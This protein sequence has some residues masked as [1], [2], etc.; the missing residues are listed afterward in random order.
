[1]FTESFPTHKILHQYS[2]AHYLIIV[3]VKEL[4]D[5]PKICNWEYNRP[6]D[7]N[8]CEEIAK[9]Y[10]DSKC[11]LDTMFYMAYSTINNFYKIIDGI[12]RYTALK[13]L[14]KENS[15]ELDLITYGDFGSNNDANFI[16]NQY[17]LCNIRINPSEYILKELFQNLN[18]SKP[19]PELYTEEN[20]QA[21]KI[22]IVNQIVS[23]W[24]QK[25]K[26]HFSNST[27]PNLPNTNM[28]NF[29]ELVSY[30]YD[31]YN[32]S[33]TNKELLQQILNNENE[34]VKSNPPKK[35]SI[36][37]LSKCIK[38]GC[39]LFLNKHE[40]LMRNIH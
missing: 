12:H 20:R 39:Y 5:N 3:Q 24:Y 15:K 1:M 11:M 26:Q 14:K 10:Y 33:K 31:K 25:Y 21:E 8:R 16:Y 35:C 18:K 40:I 9:Y 17:I 34:F 13:H 7:L 29:T 4:L 36:D 23:L 37:A 32:I 28:T 22:I 2:N 6:P 30:L 38:T 27:N 19:V